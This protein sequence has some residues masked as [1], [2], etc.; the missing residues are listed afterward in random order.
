MEFC[1]LAPQLQRF[2]VNT[3]HHLQRHQWVA[4]Q[5]GKQAVVAQWLPLGGEEGDHLLG[6]GAGD[7][8]ALADQLA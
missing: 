8:T 5:G 3:R 7:R 6:F 2:P 1:P 4:D